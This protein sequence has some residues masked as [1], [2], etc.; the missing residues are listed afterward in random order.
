MW[1]NWSNEPSIMPTHYYIIV[2]QLKS[3]THLQF[4]VC[5]FELI[6]GSNPLVASNSFS[7]YPLNIIIWCL[8]PYVNLMVG[9]LPPMFHAQ[10]HKS[11][12]WKTRWV[13]D[14]KSEILMVESRLSI[15]IRLCCW[16]KSQLLVFHITLLMDISLFCSK[17]IISCCSKKNLCSWL[18]H[19][20]SQSPTAKT[21]TNSIYSLE[22]PRF[23]LSVKS[24]IS[25]FSLKLHFFPIGGIC[26]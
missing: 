12:W 2:P 22:K 23:F 24:R 26:P 3:E 8:P 16:I 17:T 13:N 18:N 9:W 15:P 5:T 7:L 10:T 25:S 14:F 21:C 4:M 19:V 11:W 20:N 6:V 1:W